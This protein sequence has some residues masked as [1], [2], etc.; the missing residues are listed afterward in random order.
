MIISIFLPLLPIL[1]IPLIMFMLLLFS[2]L[3]Y[4]KT[5]ITNDLYISVAFAA[6]SFLSIFLFPLSQAD[7]LFFWDKPFHLAALTVLLVILTTSLFSANRRS[8]VELLPFFLLVGIIGI[9]Y[10]FNNI[11]SGTVFSITFIG[12]GVWMIV[13]SRY[14]IE[15]RSGFFIGIGTFSLIGQLFTFQGGQFLC[16]LLI[17]VFMMYECTLYFGRIVS[18]VKRAGINSISDSLTGLFNKGYLLRKAEQIVNKQ[19]LHIIF[20]DIDNFKQLNDTKG[21]DEGDKVLIAVGRLLQDALYNKGLACRAGGEEMVG[22]VTSGDATL[23]ANRFREQVEKQ[24]S[25]TVSIGVASGNTDSK[26]IIKLADNRMY[27]A[28]SSGKNRV[29]A[30]GGL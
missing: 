13:S 3:M 9:S 30:E 14:D 16:S 11:I 25:V 6:I 2:L 28:K 19:E 26:A 23:I 29:V 12:Y 1:Y 18:L 4:R 15:F 27:L 17:L 22:I 24:T 20:I 8:Y 7:R 21:H 10:F 5:K